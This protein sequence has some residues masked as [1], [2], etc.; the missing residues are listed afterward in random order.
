MPVLTPPE[1]RQCVYAADP[2]A[3]QT[4]CARAFEDGRSRPCLAHPKVGHPSDVLPNVVWTEET[5]GTDV[6]WRG[7]VCDRSVSIFANTDGPWEWSATWGRGSTSAV[8]DTL[9]TT[10]RRLVL[11]IQ[12]R[13]NWDGMRAL[14]AAGGDLT[15][16]E[17]Q[18]EQAPQ[19]D[20]RLAA[21]AHYDDAREVVD[22]VRDQYDDR[23]FAAICAATAFI[24]EARAGRKGDPVGDDRKARWWRQMERHVNG[25]DDDPRVARP[26]FQPYAR[27]AG[28]VLCHLGDGVIEPG[29]YVGPVPGHPDRVM[30]RVQT[31]GHFK[32]EVLLRN[33][34]VPDTRDR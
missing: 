17:Q 10:L 27:L 24:Y 9:A 16:T 18:Q 34:V 29:Y 6:V 13:L 20:G 15:W 4:F 11:A 25:A 8:G 26:S 21:P 5:D 31:P 28:P 1:V 33:C 12:P 14:A 32:D 23:T 7:D 3:C 19:P 22:Q 2:N 30:V